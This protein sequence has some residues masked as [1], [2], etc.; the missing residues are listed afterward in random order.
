ME[1]HHGFVQTTST[2][3]ISLQLPRCVLPKVSI[4]DFAWQG[5]AVSQGLDPKDLRVEG[6][7]N[8]RGPCIER[9]CSSGPFDS[10]KVCGVGSASGETRG[11]MATMTATNAVA[12][13]RKEKA[14]NTVNPEVY[15]TKAYQPRIGMSWQITIRLH[16]GLYLDPSGGHSNTQAL[17]LQGCVAKTVS[18]NATCH[19]NRTKRDFREYLQ[20]RLQ[21]CNLSSN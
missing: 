11:N 5:R 17:S 21:V 8:N 3:D 18:R 13:L 9:S 12:M 14:P 16:C 2:H 15:D 10:T 4:P 7:R 20:F 6:D 19:L 1:A